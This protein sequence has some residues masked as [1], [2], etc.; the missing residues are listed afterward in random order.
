MRDWRGAVS[1]FKIRC[2]SEKLEYLNAAEVCG[3][4]M[5]EGCYLECMI[6]C[7]MAAHLFGKTCLN[8]YTKDTQNFR[9]RALE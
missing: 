3:Q 6:S 8:Y 4:I 7:V 5:V 1:S 9:S 2:D